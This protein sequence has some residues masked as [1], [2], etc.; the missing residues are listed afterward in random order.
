[1]G[2]W[3]MCLQASPIHV[4]WRSRRR[5]CGRSKCRGGLNEHRL[6]CKQLGGVAHQPTAFERVC[7]STK[8]DGIGCARADQ[9]VLFASL[10]PPDDDK[11]DTVS[12]S[13]AQTLEW[14]QKRR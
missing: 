6:F 9:D 1:M 11:G 7:S 12:S 5:F 2:T 3:Q 8:P 14:L 4:L 10:R 13:I